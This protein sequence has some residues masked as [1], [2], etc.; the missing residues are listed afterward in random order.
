MQTATEALAR[1]RRAAAGRRR[2]QRPPLRRY[3]GAALEEY[4]A[5]APRRPPSEPAPGGGESRR[6]LVERYVAASCAGCSSGPRR[7]PRR[8]PLAADRLRARR[9]R[10]A[11]AAAARRRSSSTRRPYRFERARARARA[12]TVLDGLARAR[13]TG[14]LRHFARWICSRASSATIR[15]HGLIE[16]GGEVLCLVS[17]GADSTCLRARAARARLPRLGA[18]RRPRAARRRVGRRRALLR[19]GARR[20]G[21]RASTRRAAE[22]GARCAPSATPSAPDALRAT[23]HTASD[24][25]ETILYRLVTSGNTQGDQAPARGRRRPPAARGLARGDRGVLPRARDRLPRRLVA[26]RRPCAA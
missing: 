23:G 6:G 17:G 8:R 26:T 1:A 25:V 12:S 15:R 22:R 10:G 13:P 20:R 11:A 18:A 2:A 5:W 21:R 3:E 7:R 19:R 9:G 24:Q 4:R 16:P 14:E